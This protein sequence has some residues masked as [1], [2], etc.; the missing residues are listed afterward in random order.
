MRTR[1][2]DSARWTRHAG[3][4]DRSDVIKGDVR[5]A[6]VADLTADPSGRPVEPL[7]RVVL[8]EI[9]PGV[10][11]AHAHVCRVR[12]RS[13]LREGEN[14]AVF[15]GQ[16]GSSFFCAVQAQTVQR[17]YGRRCSAGGVPP[18]PDDAER[19]GAPG[20]EAAEGTGSL[21]GKYDPA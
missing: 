9:L 4:V 13:D 10:A 17:G 6:L 5:A 11:E 15:G 2:R 16:P 8:P 18:A 21:L 3:E 19:L 14:V 1:Q 12:A 7:C 20:G